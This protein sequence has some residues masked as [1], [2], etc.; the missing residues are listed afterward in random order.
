M[1]RK[2]QYFIV[3]CSAL[4]VC[5]VLSSLTGHLHHLLLSYVEEKMHADYLCATFTEEIEKYALEEVELGFVDYPDCGPAIDLLE[6]SPGGI[7]LLLEEATT[8]IKSN[9]RALADKIIATHAKSKVCIL[10]HI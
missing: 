5:F 8:Q 7:I 6:K 9:D 2:L 4:R 3:A 10:K 1:I